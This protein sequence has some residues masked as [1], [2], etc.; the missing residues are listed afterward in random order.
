L[1]VVFGADVRSVRRFWWNF[2]RIKKWSFD[3][4]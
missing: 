3:G 2:V 4:C 1:L